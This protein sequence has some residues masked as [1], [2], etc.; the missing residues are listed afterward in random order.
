MKHLAGILR[1]PTHLHF[2]LRL[3]KWRGSLGFTARFC[4]AAFPEHYLNAPE[5]RKHGRVRPINKGDFIR[6]RGADV[7]TIV[8]RMNPM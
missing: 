8:G 4:D 1:R 7:G 6:D 5:L 2:G 3:S